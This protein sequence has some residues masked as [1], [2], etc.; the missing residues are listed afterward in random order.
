MCQAAVI[1]VFATMSTGTKSMSSSWLQTML[2]I[3][4]RAHSIIIPVI[5]LMLSTQPGNGS[6][7]DAVTENEYTLVI[8]TT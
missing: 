8:L 3:V 7:H 2:L 4:P 5:P 1:K 6:F